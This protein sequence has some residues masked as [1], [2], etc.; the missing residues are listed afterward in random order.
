[1]TIT[2]A[3]DFS[4]E[5]S[6]MEVMSD[7]SYPPER[8]AVQANTGAYSWKISNLTSSALVMGVPD[9]TTDLRA[10]MFFWASD[11][12]GWGHD[13]IRGDM[14]VFALHQ[15]YTTNYGVRLIWMEDE[16]RLDLSIDGTVEDTILLSAI[17][18]WTI[19]TWL[20][21]GITA[22]CTSGYASVYFNG[23][24]ILTY[25]GSIAQQ[26]W[27]CVKIFARRESYGFQWGGWVDDGYVDVLDSEPDAAPPMYRF[28]PSYVVAAGDDA[29]FTQLS[30]SN[31]QMVDDGAAPDDD[32]T[33]NKAMTSA[34]SLK[35]TF[36][37]DNIA[38][39]TDYIIVAAHPFAIVRKLDAGEDA[40]IK[41]TAWDGATLAEGAAQNIPI[42]YGITKARM[43]TQ[44]D[45]SDWNESD[46]NAMQFGYE[47]AGS[48]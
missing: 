48:F 25:S 18:D 14:N 40:Q 24:Q 43:T 38:V 20:H 35:D 16:Q 41:N 15:R 32:T 36:D 2:R 21:V 26:P 30:G 22:S 9:G 13:G 28:L 1:M 42:T 37:C 4:G 17:P 45:G 11:D 12:E 46:F 39:P 23:D 8:S 27:D 5:I 44:P 6:D 34:G 3:W 33:Y 29:D 10:A 31:Y 47:A 19:E 7:G